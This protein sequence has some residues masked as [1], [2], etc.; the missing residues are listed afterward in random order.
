MNKS[1]SSSRVYLV[2]ILVKVSFTVIL[3]FVLLQKIS[4]RDIF[5]LNQWA[6]EIIK[7]NQTLPLVLGSTFTCNKVQAAEAAEYLQS[8]LKLERIALARLLTCW[9]DLPK[10][11]ILFD[12]LEQGSFKFDYSEWLILGRLLADSGY[13][14]EGIRL[15]R[16]VP[17]WDIYLGLVGSVAFERGD[18]SGALNLYNLS[19]TVNKRVVVGKLDMYNK[20]CELYRKDPAYYA[21]ETAL[22]YCRDL[23]QVN[24]QAGPLESVGRLYLQL[25]EDDQARQA[26]EEIKRIAPNS[27]AGYMWLGILYHRQGQTGLAEQALLQGI[28]AEPQYP[29]TY[30]ILAELYQDSKQ[31]KLAIEQL[32]RVIEIGDP[33]TMAQAR[34]LLLQLDAE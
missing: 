29:W 26:F 20:L 6:T 34:R 28:A 24:Y 16:R 4:V 19:E 1:S 32:T 18:I 30:L 17:D 12:S 31:Y 22:N 9:N 10:R 8:E 33:A 14:E 11:T 2:L 7:E 3:L 13:K 15:W 21:P 5:I 27:A 25:G 23:L